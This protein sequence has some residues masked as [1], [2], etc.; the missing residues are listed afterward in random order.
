ME[1]KARKPGCDGTDQIAAADSTATP[2]PGAEPRHT[3]L[4]PVDLSSESVAGEED[5]GAGL[6]VADDASRT[7]ERGR[8]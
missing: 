6:D 3:A 8:R 2:T 5:P 7:P 4:E 1:S